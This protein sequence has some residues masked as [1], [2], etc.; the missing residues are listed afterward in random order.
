[1]PVGRQT[2]VTFWLSGVQEDPE[3]GEVFPDKTFDALH[4]VSL[5]VRMLFIDKAK[6]RY[7]ISMI[8]AKLHTRR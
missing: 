8:A 7:Q 4:F 6:K 3:I 2:T 1:M 5:Q